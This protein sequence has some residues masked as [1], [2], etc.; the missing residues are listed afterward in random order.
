VPGAGFH[1][2]GPLPCAMGAGAMAPTCTFGVKREG[3]GNGMVRLTKPDG[4]QR[5][6][7]F[8]QGRATGH[9]ASQADKAAF[10]ATRQGDST[11]V[12]IGS[13]RYEIPDAVING[14]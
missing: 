8:Q 11:I 13:E 14:G 9:D 4:S 6:V 2:T 10:R 12:T 3:P 7:F 1:A 5:T